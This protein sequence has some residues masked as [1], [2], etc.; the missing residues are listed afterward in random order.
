MPDKEHLLEQIEKL[1]EI[2]IALSAEKNTAHLLELIL[3]GAKT[4]TNAD[5]GTIYS[6]DQE[7]QTVKMEI[8]RTD[9]PDVA[10]GGTTGKH[11]WLFS[12]S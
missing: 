8:V 4:L 2:G 5:G 7:N 10:T 12:L 6:V 3:M 9:S 11:S 1:T